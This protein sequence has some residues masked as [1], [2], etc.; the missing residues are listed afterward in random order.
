MIDGADQKTI[1]LE[2]KA[3]YKQYTLM[4]ISDRVT[5]M[6]EKAAKKVA[7]DILNSYDFEQQ[8][9]TKVSNVTDDGKII[10]TSIFTPKKKGGK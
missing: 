6:C 2:V 9:K 4:A 7:K 3:Y 8:I 1:T 10:I 5:K